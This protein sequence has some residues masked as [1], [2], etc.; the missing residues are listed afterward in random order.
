MKIFLI[1]VL[2]LLLLFFAVR[3]FAKKK[4]ASLAGVETNEKILQLSDANFNHQLKN[5][6]ILV[7]FWADWCM[8]CKMM[9]PILND[10]AESLPENYSVAKLD[11][12]NNHAVAQKYNVRS[13][14]TLIL[15][16]NGK[17]VN[18]FVGVKTK[19]FLLKEI[20]KY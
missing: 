19:D 12:D 13:I 4:M 20:K 11:V 9:L 1:I 8:P 3:I 16:Q 15:F 6:T 7:D 10:L 14:P 18:R 17:E 2:V 5:K